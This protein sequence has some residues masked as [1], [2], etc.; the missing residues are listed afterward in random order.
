MRCSV[1]LLTFYWHW[2]SR[3]TTSDS[4]HIVTWWLSDDIRRYMYVE[5]LHTPCICDSMF[6]TH[7]KNKQYAVC[8]LYLYNFTA[9]YVTGLDNVTF[10]LRPGKVSLNCMDVWTKNTFRFTKIATIMKIYR[11]FNHNIAKTPLKHPRIS[12][13]TNDFYFNI[14]VLIAFIHI[15][16]HI[17]IYCEH[18][19]RSSVLNTTKSCIWYE[20]R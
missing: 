17:Y 1:Y 4:F 5:V 16:I 9:S 6:I 7:Q 3:Q 10:V 19:I 14:N 11:Y 20:I 15:Y 18:W 8:S 2:T 12:K 13:T